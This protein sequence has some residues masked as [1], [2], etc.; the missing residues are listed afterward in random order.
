M[1][2]RTWNLILKELIQLWRDRLLVLFITLGPV[3]ELVLVAWATSGEIERIP[4][5]I[6]D[7]DRSPASR[8]LV[9]ALDNSR[10]F[11]PRFY[12]DDVEAAQDLVER[13]TALVA[14][15]IPPDFQEQL[16]DPARGPAQVQVILD[17]AEASVAQ[18]ALLSAEGVV[19]SYAQA[20]MEA[21][22]SGVAALSVPL[23]AL[24]MRVQTWFNEALKLS[25]YEVPSELGFMLIGVALMISSLSIARERELGT[26]EQLLVTPMRGMELVIGKAVPAIVLAYLDFLL[27]LGLVLTLF[28][29][30]MR[31]SFALLLAIAFFYLLVEIGWGLMVSAVSRTQWQALLLV[32]SLMMGEM[33]FSGYASPVENMP[34]LLRN[35]A[36]LVP[37][38]HWLIILR[39]ILLKGAGVEVFWRELLALAGLGVVI[40]LLTLAVLRRRLE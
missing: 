27:M 23:P 15:L 6:V 40:N 25:Y 1:I 39:S 22:R 35:A 36:N 32:F 7:L 9:Q 16:D 14:V 2:Y 21:R 31:G 34:W 18:T 4:T 17:G 19:G 10:T 13:G 38:K 37:I 28:H 26:L 29:I 3:M 5:A 33:I 12:P 24:E 11:D 8:S 20:R 30:P